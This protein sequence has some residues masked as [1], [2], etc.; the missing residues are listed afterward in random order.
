MPTGDFSNESAVVF[1]KLLKLSLK[2]IV[3]KGLQMAVVKK[4]AQRSGVSRILKRSLGQ[5]RW[6]LRVKCVNK[7]QNARQHGPI[8]KTIGRIIKHLAQANPE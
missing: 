8:L 3:V 1:K 5:W 4:Y 7:R 2:L 6:L